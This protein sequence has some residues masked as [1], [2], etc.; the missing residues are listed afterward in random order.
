MTAT[1]EDTRSVPRSDSRSDSRSDGRKRPRA[2]N[3]QYMIAPSVPGSTKKKLID[4]LDRMGGIEIVRTYAERGTVPP[5]VAVVRMSDETATALRRS[6][7]DALV[8]EPDR[9]L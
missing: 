8:I 7:G 4:R 9:I 5:P 6:A 1:A 3:S 2:R